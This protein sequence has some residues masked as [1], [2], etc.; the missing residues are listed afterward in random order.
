M[1]MTAEKEAPRRRPIIWL[2][3]PHIDVER[4]LLRLG[5]RKVHNEFTP[6][7]ITHDV[8]VG[9]IVPHRQIERS[10]SVAVLPEAGSFRSDAFGMGWRERHADAATPHH[11]VI[12][13]AF[14]PDEPDPDQA[15][16]HL[17]INATA[18]VAV[19]TAP[20]PA[21][22]TAWIGPL[23]HVGH[24]VWPPASVNSRNF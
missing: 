19:P 16:G 1:M 10:A 8:N 17:G 6:P 11:D 23:N 22:R 7:A 3:F 18:A 4:I 2:W 21:A 12:G 15:V 24:A 14:D 13:E 20:A 5:A 9:A